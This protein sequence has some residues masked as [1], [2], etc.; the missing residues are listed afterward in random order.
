MSPT[1]ASSSTVNSF[2]LAFYGRPADPAGLKFW[3]QQLDNANGDLSNISN[4]FATSTEAQTRFGTDSVSSRIGEIYQQLF[5]RAPDAA[6][7]AYWQD[8]VS[9]GHASM[10]DVALAV[11]NGSQGKDSTLVELRKSAMDKFTAQIEAT[12]SDYAGYAAIEAAQVLVRAVTLDTSAADMDNLVKS[13]VEFAAVATTTPG[14][15]NAIASGGTLA[16]LFASTPGAADPVALVQTLAAIAKAG[17]ANPGTLA[18][19]QQQGG[20]AEILKSMPASVSLQDIVKTLDTKGLAAAIELAHPAVPAT[21]TPPTASPAPTPPV[22]TPTP[23]PTFALNLAFKGV[24]QGPNDTNTDIITNLPNVSVQFSYTGRDLRANQHFESSTDGTH[25]SSSHIT[26]SKTD[27]TVTIG[28]VDLTLGK[29]MPRPGNPLGVDNHMDNLNTKVYLRAVDASGATTTPVSQQVVYKQYVN[30]PNVVF[31]HAFGYT[32]NDGTFH[33]ASVESDALVEYLVSPGS[34]PSASS[35]TGWTTEAPT[36]HEGINNFSIRQTDTAGNVSEIRNISFTLDTH[37]PSAPVIALVSDNG[38]DT[39]DRITSVAK[40]AISGLET[41]PTTSW[42]YSL[43][44]GLHWDLR[45]TS[46]GDNTGSDEAVLDLG[47]LADGAFDV[48]VRQVDRAGNVSIASNA[49]AF[50]LDS[51]LPGQEL[52]FYGVEQ[53]RPERGMTNL[54]SADVYFKYHG[55]DAAQ[56]SFEYRLDGGGWTALDHGAYDS[57]TQT[58]TVAKVDL[59]QADR[60]VEVRVID[61]FG[62]AGMPVGQL[63]DSTFNNVAEMS[64]I[65]FVDP[66]LAENPGQIHLAPVIDLVDQATLSL[67]DVST[68]SATDT[69]TSYTDGLGV[70]VND[71]TLFLNDTPALDLYVL[72]WQD[73]TFLTD[74]APGIGRV[75]AGSVTLVGGTAGTAQV[76]GFVVDNTVMLTGDAVNINESGW[77]RVNTAFIDDGHSTARIHTGGGMDVIADNGGT[78]IISYAQG[79]DSDTDIILG[80]DSGND[81]VEVSDAGS[82]IRDNGNGTLD[83]VI[84]SGKVVVGNSEAVELTTDGIISTGKSEQDIAVTLATLNNGLDLTGIQRH[85]GLLILV[86]GGDYAAL[87]FYLNQDDDP[88]I[89]A[90]E[91]MLVSVFDNGSIQTTDIKLVGSA[92]EAHI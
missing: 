23:E 27:H 6:G 82:P 15:V 59:S 42:Q 14:V 29:A 83:W 16:E 19:L 43:D 25:W 8:V 53:P 50:T 61:V 49:V 26:V 36:I 85:D 80:F 92:T 60:N 12:G 32:G 10:A 40:I 21:P 54:S 38:P 81:M 11:L 45:L 68:G 63:I 28:N 2:Y 30:A 79:A 47:F 70:H 33:L 37:A 89:S 91:L 20:M 1:S 62:N 72:S 84:G 9:R 64:L 22:P 48:L 66:D 31:D 13:T 18:T 69:A 65:E 86:N 90:D 67:Q 5:N 88:T 3:I 78:L 39:T 58:L 34:A 56:E 71:R 52:G 24:T 44:G 51:I 7:L 57:T 4:A 41:D 76:H 35:T 74:Y 77:A 46:P 73:H 55:E 75:A 87:A 17:A